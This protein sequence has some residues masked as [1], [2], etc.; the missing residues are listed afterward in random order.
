MKLKI[1]ACAY[2]LA[3]LLASICLDSRCAK[4][5]GGLDV[6][7]ITSAASNSV[8]SASQAASSAGITLPNANAGGINGSGL[9][10]GVETGPFGIGKPRTFPIARYL[11]ERH[12]ANKA[13]LR[14]SPLGKLCKGMLKPLSKLT[15]GVVPAEPTPNKVQLAAPGPMGSAAKI[16]KDQ[17][18]APK[19][20]AAIQALGE[21]DCHWYPEALAQLLAALRSDRSE[22]VRFEA[23]KLLTDCGC[24]T[25]A[26]LNALRVCVAGTETDG[27]PGERSFR[28]RNQASIALENCLLCAGNRDLQQA[29]QRRPEYPVMPDSAP[30]HDP[31]GY[32]SD[33]KTLREVPPTKGAIAQ[34][35]FESAVPG[36]PTTIDD[37][38]IKRTQAL[39]NQFRQEQSQPAERRR[40]SLRDVW[41]K[42][43]K[44]P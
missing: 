8:A 18:E 44:T 33:M 25:P 17:L 1:A 5:Q 43:K 23:A 26:M 9:A 12:V 14:A 4:A 30:A 15:G 39:L 41:Q 20:L 2:P 36:S 19:R 42:S 10:G 27:N 16:K 40:S 28:I 35:G 11:K 3:L 6:S 22:C 29:P 31:S 37:D 13:K 21:V 34:V 24:C 32:Y 7:G 38:S